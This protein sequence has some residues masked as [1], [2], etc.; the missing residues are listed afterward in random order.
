[1]PMEAH[2]EPAYKVKYPSGSRPAELS[3]GV[4]AVPQYHVRKACS[5]L[6]PGASSIHN[7]CKT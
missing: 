7:P 4:I 1:M 6:N 5:G 3:V 2:H